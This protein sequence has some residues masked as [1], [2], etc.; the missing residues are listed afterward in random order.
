MPQSLARVLIHLVFSTKNREPL[1]D[2]PYNR[3]QPRV[4]TK[5]PTLG[6]VASRLRRTE[7]NAHGPARLP[8]L[9]R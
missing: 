1:G 4:G 9:S 8:Y 5:T 6:C 2:A 3:K 7:Q